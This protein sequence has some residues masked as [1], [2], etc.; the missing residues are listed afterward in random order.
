[1]ELGLVIEQHDPH[2]SA[3]STGQVGWPVRFRESKA[4]SRTASGDMPAYPGVAL[5]VTMSVGRRGDGVSEATS[6][7]W[8]AA[9]VAAT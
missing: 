6:H 3:P 5:H 7:S 2:S 4:A 9:R 1:M 8:C